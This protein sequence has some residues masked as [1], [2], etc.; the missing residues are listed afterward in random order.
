M[1]P[2]ISIFTRVKPGL[3]VRSGAAGRD[4]EWVHP[5]SPPSRVYGWLAEC[6]LKMGYFNKDQL[7][8][9]WCT[10]SRQIFFRLR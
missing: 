6:E 1:G 3:G 5:P 9:T 10:L 7:F 4:G 8:K 2:P